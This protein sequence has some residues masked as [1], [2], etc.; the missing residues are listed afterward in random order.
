M[1]LNPSNSSNLERLALKGLIFYCSN[2]IYKDSSQCM[3]ISCDLSTVFIRIH[4][5]IWIC[6]S[7]GC[8][9]TNV[10][11]LYV[12]RLL[13]SLPAYVIVER[14]PASPCQRVHSNDQR[15]QLHNSVLRHR[16]CLLPAGD[17]MADDCSAESGAIV[18]SIQAS[19]AL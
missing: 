18:C 11:F 6:D 10:I 17:T 3:L 15:T 5:W 16:H 9:R 8:I 4:G 13:H 7:L 1:A 14:A 12:Y 19:R 2:A